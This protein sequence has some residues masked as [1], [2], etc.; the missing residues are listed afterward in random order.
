MDV[1]R[2]SKRILIAEFDGNPK[3]TVIVVYAPTNCAELSDVEEFYSDLKSTL[4]D[5]PAHNF[6]AVIGDFNARIGTDVA[7]FTFHK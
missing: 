4:N 3:T 7:L 2:I 1:K 6:L 5:V